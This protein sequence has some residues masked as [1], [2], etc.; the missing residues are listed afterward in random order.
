MI[1][2]IPANMSRK[3]TASRVFLSV[4][5]TLLPYGLPH[6]LSDMHGMSCAESRFSLSPQSNNALQN[7]NRTGCD[8]EDKPQVHPRII[9][10][11]HA[12]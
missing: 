10:C 2:M 12:L 3:Q 1:R 9:P 5:H 6:T 4:K 11:F 7:Q 8:K